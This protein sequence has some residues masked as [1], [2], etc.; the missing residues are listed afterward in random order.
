MSEDRKELQ[1]LLFVPKGISWET[2]FEH[3]VR[4]VLRGYTV[5][6]HEHAYQDDC[7]QPAPG[8]HEGRISRC[9]QLTKQD[10][11]VILVP[12]TAS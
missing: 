4:L 12:D 10:N 8:S 1:R 7:G 3:G 5:W 2:Q 9:G 6:L 11:G